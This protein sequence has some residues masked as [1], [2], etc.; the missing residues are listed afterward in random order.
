MRTRDTPCTRMLRRLS[1]ARTMRSTVASVPT[2][3]RSPDAST[4]VGILIPGYGFWV[5]AAGDIVFPGVAAGAAGVI[6]MPANGVRVDGFL[7]P[8]SRR[9]VA[10]ARDL[11]VALLGT[12]PLRAAGLRR[13]A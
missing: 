13:D 7:A 1:P 9:R 8:G 12:D 11:P 4:A 3:C 6:G 2:P 10:T 5:G